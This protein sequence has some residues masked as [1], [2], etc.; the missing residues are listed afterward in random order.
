MSGVAHAA[1]W[2]VVTSSLDEATLLATQ[3]YTAE[4]L[5]QLAVNMAK[6]EYGM[7]L[8]QGAI[9]YLRTDLFKHGLQG[10]ARDVRE[11]VNRAKKKHA[12]RCRQNK[13]TG[14]KLST[15]VLD[16]SDFTSCQGSS[17]QT[18]APPPPPPQPQPPQSPSDASRIK[19]LKDLLDRGLITKEEYEDG[20]AK[21]LKRLIG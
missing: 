15:Y 1:L 14:P 11:A 16:E 3:D 10:N 8:S 12:T 9:N 2:H 5:T 20:K 13:E 4:E 6:S 17:P 7:T 21:C 19:E 18:V